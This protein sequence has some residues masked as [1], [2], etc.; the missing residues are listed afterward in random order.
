MKPLIE[1]QLLLREEEAL[2]KGLEQG[3]I[4]GTVAV[5]RDLGYKDAEIK[6]TIEKKYDLS[7]E[8]AEEYLLN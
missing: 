5:L 7:S 4:Q 2:K 1:P 3:R 8:E 6:M